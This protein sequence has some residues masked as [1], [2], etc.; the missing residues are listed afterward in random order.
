MGWYPRN[1]N[2]EIISKKRPHIVSETK[3]KND[4]DIAASLQQSLSISGIRLVYVQL[5]S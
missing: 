2:W 1:W 4:T 5:D 3:L